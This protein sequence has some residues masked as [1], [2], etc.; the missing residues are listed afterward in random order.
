MYGWN[1]VYSAR[2]YVCIESFDRPSSFYA[3]NIRLIQLGL[4][5]Y[6]SLYIYTNES[7]APTYE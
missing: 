5:V 6:I 1:I 4:S 2:L 3:R 7:F